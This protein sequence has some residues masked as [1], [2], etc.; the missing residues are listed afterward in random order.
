MRDQR[1]AESLPPAAR[2]TVAPGKSS[3]ITLKT[4]P[5]AACTL[6]PEGETNSDRHIKLY[7]DGD[8]LIRFYVRPS[9]EDE[10]VARFVID[11]EADGRATSYPLELRPHF[12]ATAEMPPPPL[13]LYQPPPQGAR[14]R[15]A[16][17]GDDLLRLPVE[18]LV[19]RGCP[20]RSNP[21]EAPGAFN[22]WRRAV[23][24]PTTIIEPHQ[25]GRPDIRIS[26]P[27]PVQPM[28]PLRP[29]QGGG[30]PMPNTF[31]L[32]SQR[33]SGFYISGQN[34]TFDLE[35]G[36]WVVP[37]VF[38]FESAFYHQMYSGCWVGLDGLY[39][40]DL[41]QAGTE[42]NGTYF[43]GWTFLGC[44]AFTQFLP[45]QATSH[46]ITNF[47]VHLGDEVFVQVWIGNVGS[48]PTLKGQ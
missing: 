36:T 28:P 25:V 22:T 48:A 2:Y 9:K 20:I 14:V 40:S 27:P 6:R 21:E 7:A 1:A 8:G 37:P 39:P 32:V 3:Q 47:P 30:Q 34:G 35:T 5:H 18:G 38:G 24:I 16:L 43:L 19:M 41:V 31:Q 44:S 29:P 13:E 10:T 45:Q 12:Q 4:L 17:L 33:W 46:E 15:P 42:H 11:C 23:S 26:P